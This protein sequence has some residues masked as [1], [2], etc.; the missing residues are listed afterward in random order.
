MKFKQGEAR[1]SI[2]ATIATSIYTIATTSVV[3]TRPNPS[4]LSRSEEEL[5][6]TTPLNY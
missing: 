3:N 1:S 6:V 4:L 2:G 5:P